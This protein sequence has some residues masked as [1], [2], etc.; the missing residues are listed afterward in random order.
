[1]AYKIT[2]IPD[3]DINLGN[4]NGEIVQLTD[5]TSDYPTGGYAIIDG[6]SVVNNSALA[7]NVDLYRVVVAEPAGGQGGYNI[8]W[9]PATKKIQVFQ[10]AA[11]LGPGTEVPANTDLSAYTFQLLLAGQ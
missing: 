11:G 8:V 6:V 5:S 10:G 9:N 3:G 2:K 7:Q 4:L 1:M